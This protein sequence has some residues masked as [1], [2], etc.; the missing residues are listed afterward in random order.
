MTQAGMQKL[1]LSN[2]LSAQ[3]F[4]L[5]CNFCGGR[6][7]LNM[8]TTEQEAP[9]PFCRDGVDG[10]S[11]R[12]FKQEVAIAMPEPAPE[13]ARAKTTIWQH[14]YTKQKRWWMR[15]RYCEK[16]LEDLL[17]FVF[18]GNGRLVAAVLGM[19]VVGGVLAFVLGVA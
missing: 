7:S 9:C 15:R 14:R 3:R 19:A 12:F 11:S 4:E 2:T 10:Q 6:L 17:D 13:S 1:Y 5:D 8:P 16:K 18:A